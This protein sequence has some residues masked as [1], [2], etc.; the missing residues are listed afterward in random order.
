[1]KK[2][3]KIAEHELPPDYKVFEIADG[4]R[5]GA[6]KRSCFFCKHCDILVDSSGPYHV[7]CELFKETDNGLAGKCEN[8]EEYEEEEGG[9]DHDPA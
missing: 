9:D 3:R 8:F 7:N 5:Y 2:I 4:R 6:H 1:M